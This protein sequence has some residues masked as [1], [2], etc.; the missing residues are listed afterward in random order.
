MCPHSGSPHT[1]L[2][3]GRASRPDRRN[4]GCHGFC[5]IDPMKPEFEPKDLRVD[6]FRQAI[7]NGKASV[8]ITHIP[9]GVEARAEGKS[10]LQ[11]RIIAI[12][13]IRD[14]VRFEVSCPK[15]GKSDDLWEG[16]NVEVTAWRPLKKDGSPGRV[17]YD[18]GLYGD[19][20]ASPDG[21]Y[22][23]SCGWEGGKADLEVEFL[24]DSPDKLFEEQP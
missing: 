7:V 19:E 13:E 17:N 24:Y 2:E 3:S 6:I 10:E 4:L 5:A 22:G 12:N 9:S 15:C 1:G 8:K 14:K 18:T 21:A 23:C 16:V 11:A 20:P